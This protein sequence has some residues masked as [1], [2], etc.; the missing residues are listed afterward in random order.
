MGYTDEDL[1]KPL[2]GVANPASEVTPCNVHLDDLAD[3][4]KGGVEQQGGLPLEFG[5]ITISDVIATGHEGIK[6]SLVSREVIADS[7]ELVV[8]S[9]R[10]DALVT[11]GGCDKNL[12]GMMMAAAR[13]DVPS[14]FVYGGTMLPGEYEGEQI[15]VQDVFEGVGEYNRGNL[16]AESLEELEHAAC[17][18]AG[19]CAG[20]YTA[21][22]M[23]AV[24][25]AIGMSPLG[26]ST[27]PA[28]SGR[29]A[30]VATEAG[31]AVLAALRSD[32]TP[33]DVLTPAAFENAI[34]TVAA[35]GGSTNAVLH[36]LALADEVDVDIDIDDFDRV[37]RETPQLCNLRPSGRF[38]MVDLDNNGGV[39]A[40]LRRLLDGGYLH[41]EALTVTGETL[42]EA[43]DGREI[44]APNPEVVRPIDDPLYEQGAIVVLKGS[45]APEGAV[46]KVTGD[47]DFRF[48]GPARVFDDK[49]RAYDAVRADEVE[50]GSVIIVRNEGPSGGPGMPGLL[51]ITSAVV[52]QGLGADVA[53]VTDGRFSGATRGP[54]I[55]HVAPEAVAGGPLA[56]VEDGDEIVIDIPD[57]RLDVAVSNATLRSRLDDW[58]PPPSEE[59]VRVLRRY[60]GLFESAAR[61]APT[62]VPEGYGYDLDGV[63]SDWFDS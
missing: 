57:R 15:T 2:V 53:L 59:P 12:P 18:G 54:M 63:D 16:D 14:V 29:R 35:I 41:G 51:D 23:A 33:T 40:V 27:P 8:E 22:T 9:E 21:N 13:L 24:A 10:I 32:V 60:G 4:A 30:S 49:Q 56:V 31:E 28:E 6:T 17:P 55:G 44:A 11:F 3:R 38:V 25:E 42:R 45:L 46:I 34:A 47:R 37:T 62:R 7:V 50:A 61:G 52:G 39:P 36:L 48:S 19:S 20:M 26:S 43:L 1:E 5:T 58:S